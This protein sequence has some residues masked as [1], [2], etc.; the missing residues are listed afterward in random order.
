MPFNTGNPVP[1]NAGE[2]LDDNCRFFDEFAAGT[3]ASAVDRLG[4]SRKTIAGMEAEFAAAEAAR[5][6]EYLDT[7]A[8]VGYQFAGDYAAGIEITQYNQV[9]RDSS[10]EFWR[11]S[12]ST[13]LPYTTTGAGLPEGGNFVY[14]GDAVLRQELGGDGGAGKVASG[15]VMHRDSISG[16]LSISTATIPDGQQ[17]ST[18]E[19]VFRWQSADKS[20]VPAEHSGGP[21]PLSVRNA[22]WS[23]WAKPCLLR[24]VDSLTNKT[25]MTFSQSDGAV[26]L[27]VFDHLRRE[28]KRYIISRD[29]S[30][31]DHNTGAIAVGNGRVAV[32]YPGRKRTAGSTFSIYGIEFGVDDDPTDAEIKTYGTGG[33][34]PNAYVSDGSIMLL[35]RNTSTAGAQQWLT[36]VGDWPMDE[37]QPQINFFSS[38]H[39]WPYFA[40]R[41]SRLDNSVIN[42]ALGW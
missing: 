34:Y 11:V 10:G 2:D 25:Y 14:A 13:E 19:G 6:A 30:A 37:L 15:V 5:Q 8:N 39:S 16:M 36:R 22:M 20:W 41:R 33:D 42:F 27:A 24:N 7:L 32:F 31:D 1:S 21:M 18:P 26:G 28:A 35:A 17:V 38:S 40:T 12:G 9:V 4:T 29:F 23:W 3:S